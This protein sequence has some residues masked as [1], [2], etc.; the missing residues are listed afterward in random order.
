MKKLFTL[1]TLLIVAISTSWA[2]D[3]TPALPATT[4]TLPTIPTEGWK[5]AVTPTYY[6]ADNS[7]V[8]VFS[9][10]ELYQSVSNLTWTTQNSGGSSSSSVEEKSPFP[11]ASVFTGFKAATLNETSKGPYA[12]RVTNCI[13]VYAYVKSGSNKKRTITLAAYEI[14]GTG[15]SATV[16]ETATTSTTYIWHW[17]F[18]N[19]SRDSYNF[20]NIRNQ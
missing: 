9:P 6:K 7:S 19:S 18:S 15:T 10:Y 13:K 8:Y 2:A 4:L 3:L 11:A 16:A 12:Y 20:Y 5:G 17:Y 14:S 1:L